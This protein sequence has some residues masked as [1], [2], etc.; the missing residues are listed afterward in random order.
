MS[1]M[2]ALTPKASC[3]TT[4]ARC[5]G[6]GGCAMKARIG[7]PCV[8]TE[9]HC[10]LLT[11][12]SCRMDVLSRC[13]FLRMHY[14][15]P[16]RHAACLGCLQRPV[17]LSEAEAMRDQVLRV[18]LALRQQFEDRVRVGPRAGPGP[19]DAPALDHQVP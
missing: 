1:W 17:D 8:E 11:D 3:K 6:A 15:H 13:G 2:F 19:D 4:T 14:G 16:D 5:A 10:S 12:F 7:P 9:T 18:Q